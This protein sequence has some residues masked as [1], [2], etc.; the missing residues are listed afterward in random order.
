MSERITA[1]E[2][3][4]RRCEVDK[5]RH[6]TEMDGGS[7]TQEAHDDQEAY[8]RGELTLEDLAERGS[9]RVDRR[10][11]ERAEEAAP[12]AG[13]DVDE[14][15]PASSRLFWEMA[16]PVRLRMYHELY[17]LGE[18]R[19]SALAKRIG[20]SEAVVTRTLEVMETLA[21][22]GST[23][24][25]TSPRSRVWRA[26]PGSLPSG[27]EQDEP[28]TPEVVAWMKARLLVQH[29]L[30]VESVER[31]VQDPAEWQHATEMGSD[32][33]HLTPAEL[34]ELSRELRELVRKW[35]ELTRGR[36]CHALPADARAVFVVT[37][38]VLMPLP[39]RDA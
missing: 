28:V 26:I 30:L 14:R 34:D 9:A 7:R 19:A 15:S 22:V 13:D 27:I 39:G 16:D 18:M 35:V 31:R 3:A 21:V 29:N 11:A 4:R 8:V 33:F 38:T 32:V 17:V 20:S 24:Q 25:G 2:Q 37:H 6:S 10:R 5:V 1:A 23:R 36:E 12:R